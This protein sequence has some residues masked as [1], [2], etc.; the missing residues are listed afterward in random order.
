MA[1]RNT[2]RILLVDNDELMLDVLKIALKGSGYKLLA[3]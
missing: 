1:V 3:T 2:K